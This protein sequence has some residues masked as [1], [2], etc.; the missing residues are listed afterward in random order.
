MPLLKKFF[1]EVAGTEGDGGGPGSGVGVGLAV[2]SKVYPSPGAARGVWALPQPP[3]CTM[4][5]EGEPHPPC[6]PL[7]PDAPATN[8]NRPLT[9]HNYHNTD[10]NELIFE[11]VRS[12][13]LLPV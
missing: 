13:Y 3:P 9:N 6:S 7:S 1:E 4:A 5:A 12:G 2:N 8:H 11:A 10:L